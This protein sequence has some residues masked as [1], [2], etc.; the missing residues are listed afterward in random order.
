ME[1]SVYLGCY[2][3]LS[4]VTL[5]QMWKEVPYWPQQEVYRDTGVPGN[6]G[7]PK[8]TPKEPDLFV[9]LEHSDLLTAHVAPP[10]VGHAL[11]SCVC[12]RYKRD[13]GWDEYQL[14]SQNPAL[15]GPAGLC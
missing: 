6:T 11:L 8:H 13:M 14:L 9:N 2:S 10:F 15:G 4:E 7:S 3:A 12:P 1:A 5:L